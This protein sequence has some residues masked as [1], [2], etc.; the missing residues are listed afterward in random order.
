[1]LFMGWGELPSG[2]YLCLSQASSWNAQDGQRDCLL[3]R[4]FGAFSCGALPCYRTP[5]VAVVMFIISGAVSGTVTGVIW[6][7]TGSGHARNSAAVLGRRLI[8]LFMKVSLVSWRVARATDRFK[9]C[10]GALLL[11]VEILEIP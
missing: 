4:F 7:Q 9:G 11:L 1:M 2:C 8:V 3:Q 6:A 10:R 5:G